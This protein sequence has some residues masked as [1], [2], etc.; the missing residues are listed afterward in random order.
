VKQLASSLFM[1]GSA[2]GNLIMPLLGG[3]LYDIYGGNVNPVEQK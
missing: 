2:L 1:M 3:F